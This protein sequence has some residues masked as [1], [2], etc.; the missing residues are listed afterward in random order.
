MYQRRIR[1]H[2]EAGMS[3]IVLFRNEGTLGGQSLAHPHSQ[4][5]ALRRTPDGVS[6]AMR[7]TESEYAAGRCALC[8]QLKSGDTLIAVTRH[9]AAFASTYSRLPY[10]V[11]LAPITHGCLFADAGSIN[12]LAALQ[13]AVLQAFRERLGP[14]AS[15]W[16]LRT[17]SDRGVAGLHWQL[18]LAPRLTAIAG[19]EL[20]SGIFINVVTPERAA[21]ELRDSML[22]DQEVTIVR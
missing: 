20:A 18:V 7:T 4:L 22:P 19:F 8:A 21:E 5:I 16:F 14:Q 2:G 11:T 6:E 13:K 15:N 1:V 12:E 9:Y 17:A 10:E 3:Y